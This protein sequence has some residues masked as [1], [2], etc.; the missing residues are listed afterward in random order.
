MS[1]T[2]QPTI[3]AVRGS[4]IARRSHDNLHALIVAVNAPTTTCYLMVWTNTE[5]V[6]YLTIP[7][8]YPWEFN[9]PNVE[10]VGFDR[11]A[12]RACPNGNGP[13]RVSEYVLGEQLT[14]VGSWEFGDVSCRWGDGIRLSDGS[15]VF[16]SYRQD[17]TNPVA[18]LK[19]DVIYRPAPMPPLPGAADVPNPYQHLYFEWS[20]SASTSWPRNFSLVEQSGR[21]FC[22]YTG[23]SFGK[24]GRFELS[25]QGQFVAA[26]DSFIGAAGTPG[27]LMPS[28]ENP[29]IYA[30]A[31]GGSVYLSYQNLPHADHPHCEAAWGGNPV[32]TSRSAIVELLTP[33]AP[34]Q[35]VAILDWPVIHMGNPFS[36]IWPRPEGIYF[37]TERLEN[38]ANRL[39]TGFFDGTAHF[40]DLEQG[41]APA[42]SDDGWVVVA[43][44]DQQEPTLI[45]LQFKPVL[46]IERWEV[47]GK[48][49][50]SVRIGWTKPAP[51]QQ[52]QSSTDLVHW[53]DV[54]GATAPPVIVQCE[55]AQEYFQVRQTQ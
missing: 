35:V 37:M 3:T 53:T 23:D 24:I 18:K 36:W 16:A 26:N 32:L 25:L 28:G 29:Q 50:K 47:V 48:E 9:N 10:F 21:V 42:A 39:R 19:C 2:A 6:R 46:T 38:C 44:S 14:V 34:P 11:V 31:Y 27:D 52:L 30:V 54:P 51:G 4:K 7:G 22:Y 49:T 45:D 55:A 15:V 43:G 41:T 12:I 1:N 5:D 17:M 8:W 13:I 20:S 40:T 33:E